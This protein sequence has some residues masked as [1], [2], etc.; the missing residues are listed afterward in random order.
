VSFLSGRFGQFEYFDAQLGKPDWR[1]KKVL[2]FGGNQGN[3]LTDEGSTISRDH[4]WSID[5]SRDAIEEGR[6]AFPEAHWIFY[7]RYN[8]Q[9]NPTGIVGLEIP[10]IGEEF[11]Y[12]LS[13]SV[14]THIGKEEMIALVENL[15]RLLADGGT[16]AL[17]FI[18]PHCVPWPESS[19]KTNLEWRLDWAKE[20]HPKIRIAVDDVLEQARGTS[21]CA[22]TVGDLELSFDCDGWKQ[23]EQRRGEEYY[24]FYTAELM[25]DLFPRALILPPVKSEQ[26]CCLIGKDAG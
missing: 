14:F 9:F 20:D 19:G 5:V 2:D 10:D 15:K 23:L 24:T 16:L 6:A 3:I 13:Y 12:I 22:M 18:D 11:D 8:V 17:T 26:H 7:N 4:Y 25:Q 21:W 1:G